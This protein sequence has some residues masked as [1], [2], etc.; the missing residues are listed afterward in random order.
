[1]NKPIS[2][3]R[4]SVKTF[5]VEFISRGGVP[6]KKGLLSFLK[7]FCFPTC[8][9]TSNP[10]V[11]KCLLPTFYQLRSRIYREELRDPLRDT[12]VDR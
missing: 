10:T 11:V 4:F 7:P 1:M 12:A 9:E 5:L 3:C 8:R 2:G 6:G